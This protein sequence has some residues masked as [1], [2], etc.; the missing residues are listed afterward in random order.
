MNLKQLSEA[1]GVSGNEGAVRDLILEAVKERIDSYHVDALGNLICVKRAKG[2]QGERPW[3]RRVMLAAHMD[4]VGLVVT[5]INSD[6]TLRF[7]CVGGIDERVLLSKQVLVGDKAVPG[8][9]GFRPIHLIPA[10]ERQKTADI[11]KG[12]IDIGAKDRAGA[13]RLVQ[14]GDYCSFR[15]YYEVLDEGGLHTVK[16]KALDDRAGCAVLIDLLAE[17]FSFDLVAVFTTQEEVGLRGATVAAYTVKPDMALVLEGTV[18]DDLPKKVDV[19]PVTELGKGPAI[20]FMDRTLIADRR[21]VRLLAG[22]AE[23]LGIP[24][25][26]KQA[27]A[28]GTDGGAIHLAGEGVP[29]AVVAVPCRYIHAPVSVMSLSDLDHA[30]RLVREALHTCEGGLEA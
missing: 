17:S 25:Q 3:P 14:P 1:R 20:T 19:S 21:L 7:A 26:F 4:E 2:V 24:H 8:V 12:A 9:I 28:G 29:T 13:E 15:T 22:T 18:C 11:S 23:R 16:G 27:V 30:T 6:G 10:A 5:G